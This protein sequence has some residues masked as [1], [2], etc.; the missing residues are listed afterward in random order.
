MYC[1]QFS[2]SNKKKKIFMI[3][4]AFLLLTMEVNWSVPIINNYPMV[5][6]SSVNINLLFN[7]YKKIEQSKTINQELPYQ[8]NTYDNYLVPINTNNKPTK[9]KENTQGKKNKKYGS[10]E[11][12][13]RKLELASRIQDKI[14]NM[15]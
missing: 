5:L 1:Y 13:L 7:D 12:S 2:I 11:E 14:Y 4:H 10:S 6:Q 8:F 15:D 3:L 9:S